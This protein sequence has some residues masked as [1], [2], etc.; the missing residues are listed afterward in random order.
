MLKQFCQAKASF[1][2]ITFAGQ[3]SRL[4]FA[5]LYPFTRIGWVRG[6]SLMGGND[7]MVA[8]VGLRAYAWSTENGA[9]AAENCRAPGSHSGCH[10]LCGRRPD[11]RLDSPSTCALRP[12]EVAALPD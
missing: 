1:D 7:P 4:G 2:A 5:R 6:T 8:A 12:G 10:A 3:P 11:R 9:A